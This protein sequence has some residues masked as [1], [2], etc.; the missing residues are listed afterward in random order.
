MHLEY[1]LIQITKRFGFQFV[2][3][4]ILNDGAIRISSELGDFN[5]WFGVTCGIKLGAHDA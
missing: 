2:K 3:N 5:A 4:S 1:Y